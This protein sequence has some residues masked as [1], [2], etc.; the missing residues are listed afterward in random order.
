MFFVSICS[1]PTY[2]MN[3]KEE[4]CFL[5]LAWSILQASCLIYMDWAISIPVILILILMVISA[6]QNRETF[7]VSYVLISL[8]V[9]GLAFFVRYICREAYCWNFECCRGS[10]IPRNV[11]G[12]KIFN[13]IVLSN[14]RLSDADETCCCIVFCRASLSC[15]I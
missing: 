4:E 14:S 13:I 6:N 12:T 1:Y 3:N 9:T 11:S 7:L 5:F 2:T 15:S 10:W 8:A